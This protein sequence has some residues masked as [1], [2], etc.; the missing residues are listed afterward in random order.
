MLAMKSLM[1]FLAPVAQHALAAA[2][3]SMAMVVPQVHAQ[4]SEA[5]DELV[6][7]ISNDVI[8][9]IQADKTITSGNIEKVS[10]L[11]DEKIMPSV[12][13]TRMTALAVG[14]SWRQASAE[15]KQKLIDAFKGLLLRTYAGAVNQVRDVKINFLPNRSA[16][17]D[18]TVTVRTQIVSGQG[19]EPIQL[20]YRLEKSTGSWK[21]YDV[22]VLGVWLVEN[23]RTSFAQEISKTGI[24]GL[25]ASL[26]TKFN[27][28][29]PA[30]K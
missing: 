12:N 3:V 7:R 29:T 23:Y 2:A 25:I 20:E 1:K 24:D 22:N 19:G 17:E 15:Q 5:P 28:G 18:T 9:A 4:T 10:K 6:K 11:V 27:E 26:N 8:G 30:K 21:I 14:P 16:P 13:F